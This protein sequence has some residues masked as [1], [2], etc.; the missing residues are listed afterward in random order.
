[1]GGAR[2]GRRQRK[3]PRASRL[4]PSPALLLLLPLSLAA[5]SPHTTHTHRTNSPCRVSIASALAHLF[6]VSLLSRKLSGE[7][8]KSRKSSAS[9]PRVPT[10]L[11]PPRPGPIR[12]GRPNARARAPGGPRGPQV[13]PSARRRV[14]DDDAPIASSSPSSLSSREPF[15]RAR[16][17]LS[18][19]P[20]DPQNLTQ[21]LP[22]PLLH[23]KSRLLSPCTA[24]SARARA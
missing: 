1:M 24:H 14:D 4:A 11:L 8:R 19:D 2:G 13:R 22:P 12:R 15:L 9:P 10:S 7:R 6:A 21:P 5:D 16:A 3:A 20:R 23:P 17:L 18:A